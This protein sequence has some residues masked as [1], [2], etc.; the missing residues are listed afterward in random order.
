MTGIIII[1][2]LLLTGIA[3]FL[4]IKLSPEF[5]HRPN[6]K[7]KANY[8]KT[9]YYEDGKF[10][11]LT[12]T[13]IDMSFKNMLST[14]FEFVKGNKNRTPQ[15]D[16]SVLKLDSLTIAN[17]D[18]LTKITWFGHSAFLVEID[19]KKILLDPMFGDVPAPN[20]C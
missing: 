6:Y 18:T 16:I 20:P 7:D 12:P 2:I 9:G 3:G 15:S 13:S 17:N 5:G 10:V 11:N 19:G 8:A 1:S 14:I 4:F